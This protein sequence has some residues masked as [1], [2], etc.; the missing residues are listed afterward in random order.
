MSP[1]KGIRILSVCDD[2]GIRFSRELVLKQEGYEVESAPSG[3]HLEDSRICSFNIAVL[4]HS[5]SAEDAARIA[6]QLRGAN[7]S[8]SVLRVHAIR[9]MSSNFYDVDCEVFP[10]PGQLLS[11]IKMLSSRMKPPVEKLRKLA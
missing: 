8:I 6:N 5:L 11:G 1:A 4:C 9:P 3:E 10:G 7:S 2:D